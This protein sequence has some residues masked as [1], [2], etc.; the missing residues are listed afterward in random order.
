M[1]FDGM[2]GRGG[3]CGNG[4]PFGMEVPTVIAGGW[5]LY[6]VNYWRLQAAWRQIRARLTLRHLPRILA[7]IADGN[8]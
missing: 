5:C 4:V 6:R 7:V 3:K 1:E 2:H 8:L